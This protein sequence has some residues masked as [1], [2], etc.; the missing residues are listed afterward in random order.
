MLCPKEAAVLVPDACP[1]PLPLPPQTFAERLFSRVHNG[2]E[3]FETRLAA[4]T[5][6]SRVMGVHKL[7]LLNFYPFVQKYCQ[8]HQ[9]DVTQLLAAL[10]QVSA[11]AAGLRPTLACRWCM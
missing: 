2:Q 3:R 7:L 6:I 4:L 8:P 10:V 9:R 5:V 11:A 1:C